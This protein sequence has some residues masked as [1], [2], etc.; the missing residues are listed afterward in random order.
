MIEIKRD[1][2]LLLLGNNSCEIFAHF[3]VEEMHGLNYIDCMLYENNSNDAY[4]W[5]L[6]NYI[7]KHNKYYKFGDGRFV[8]ITYNDVTII[9]QLMVEFFTNLCTIH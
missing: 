2:Y 7:P 9:T 6:A 3:G 5:G 8:F 1:G 4:I